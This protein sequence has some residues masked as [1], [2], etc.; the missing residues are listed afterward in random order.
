MVA[1]Q[2]VGPGPEPPLLRPPQADLVAASLGQYRTARKKRLGRKGVDW[3]LRR[4]SPTY[5]AQAEGARSVPTPP[6]SVP[7]IASQFQYPRSVPR[8]ASQYGRSVPHMT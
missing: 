8:I 1:L 4:P 6:I 5:R 3:Y 2:H 7:H